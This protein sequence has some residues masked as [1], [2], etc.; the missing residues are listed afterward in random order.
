MSE[1]Q[2]LRGYYA[3]RLRSRTPIRALSLT[4]PWAT[5][6]VIGAKEYETRS[7][8]PVTYRHDLIAIHASKGYPG[9]AQSYEQ[10]GVFTHALRRYPVRP[11]VRGAII[12]LVSMGD[13]YPIERGMTLVSPTERAF[14]D[15]GPGRWAW[16][17]LSPLLFSEPIPIKGAL[18]L[19]KVPPDVQAQMAEM[20][21]AQL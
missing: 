5:L 4:Q 6:V 12:G 2:D 8:A 17:L 13:I 10:D 20:V 18:Q 9:W 14:G 3:D 1:S 21:E 7:W 16:K 11:L 19:W 15:F